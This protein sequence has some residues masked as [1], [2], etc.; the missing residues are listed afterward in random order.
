LAGTPNP[1]EQ[2][3]ADRQK[4]L[5]SL[6]DLLDPNATVY[7]E[8]N[9]ENYRDGWNDAMNNIYH[10]CLDKLSGVDRD[11]VI[12]DQQQWQK[13]CEQSGKQNMGSFYTYIKLG[14]M[15]RRQTYRLINLYFGNQFYG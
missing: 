1:S 10:L 2:A 5:D 7:N 3:A 4:Y 8:S 9:I 11:A 15:A 14:D 12:A 13:I 6:A